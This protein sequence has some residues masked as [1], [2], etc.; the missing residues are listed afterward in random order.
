MKTVSSKT[1][2]SNFKH[3]FHILCCF[4]R[5]SLEDKHSILINRYIWFVYQRLK[6]SK[7]YELV[8]TGS[9]TST[10]SFLYDVQISNIIFTSR[11]KSPN[12]ITLLCVGRSENYVHMSKLCSTQPGIQSSYFT[13]CTK[14]CIL[15]YNFPVS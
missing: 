7:D 6:L 11:S 1:R 4:P 13:I 12:S 15:L 3:G 10:S 14:P 2:T 9:S 5:K 8:S